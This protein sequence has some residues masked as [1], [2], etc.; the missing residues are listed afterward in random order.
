[1]KNVSIAVLMLV[2]SHSG[3]ADDELPIVTFEIPSAGGWVI[4]PDLGTLIVSSPKTAELYFIDT[5]SAEAPRK[6]RVPFKP[7]RLALQGDQLFVSVEGSSLVH[8]I[9]AQSGKSIRRYKVPGTA[10]LDL[11]C[12]HDAGPI[13]VSNVDEQVLDPRS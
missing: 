1:M 2:C 12:H 7:D 8:A 5:V 6:V 3:F 13:F 9:D 10:I 11:A 4:G